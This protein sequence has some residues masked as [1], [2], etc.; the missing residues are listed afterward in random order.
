MGLVGIFKIVD[1]GY[2][3]IDG[4]LPVLT[5]CF[6]L[7]WKTYDLSGCA[8]GSEA[9]GVLLCTSSCK[10]SLVTAGTS[11]ASILLIKTNISQFAA[12]SVKRAG[13]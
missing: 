3:K 2:K 9:G 13:L 8:G 7:S 10:G 6:A 4:L 5:L 1:I 12:Q 11:K